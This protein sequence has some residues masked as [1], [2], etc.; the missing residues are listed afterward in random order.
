[1]QDKYKNV[2]KYLILTKILSRVGRM[3]WS[4]VLAAAMYCAVSRPLGLPQIKPMIVGLKS[5]FALIM[6]IVSRLFRWLF[7][8]I[9]GLLCSGLDIYKTWINS[10]T[11]TWTTIHSRSSVLMIR[12]VQEVLF[13]CLGIF[14]VVPIAA[15]CKSDNTGSTGSTR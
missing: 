10:C 7:Y 2:K 8:S 6:F 1:M 9:D 11:S 4:A 14:T 12:D 15:E 3:G 5:R 13:Q